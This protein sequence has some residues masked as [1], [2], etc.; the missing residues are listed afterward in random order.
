MSGSVVEEAV[1][2]GD[3]K[4]GFLARGPDDGRVVLYLHGA[5]G[6]RREQ[7]WVPD[8]VLDRFEVRLVSVDRSGYGKS[9]PLT[10]G[11][12]GRV[13]DFL[14]VLDHFSVERAPV[15][16]VSSGGS[17]A[18][19]LASIAPDRIERVILSSAQMPYDDPDAIAGL[20]PLMSEGLDDA[21]AGRGP[22]LEALFEEMRTELLQDPVGALGP[23]LTTMSERERELIDR[24][25]FHDF[26]S[27]DIK[28]GVRMSIEGY[29]EDELSSVRA[30][31]IDPTTVAC[32]VRAVHGE[33][34]DWEPLPNLR[35]IL[36][37]LPDSQIFVLE[38][39]NHFGPLLYPDLV[40][41][42]AVGS[43]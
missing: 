3:R 41:S 14:A 5:P 10:G 31:E 30:F 23:A 8:E 42:L 16:G 24:P 6:S 18:L 38:G 26:L 43:D 34:D 9:D 36:D 39:L 21:R 35:R 11:R 28:E 15:I 1:R 40:I 2:N 25:W 37:R 12:P 19:T 22:R 32:A 4:V 20:D 13:G 27:E 33:L 29:I 7:Y 17:F